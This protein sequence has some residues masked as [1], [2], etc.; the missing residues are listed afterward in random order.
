MPFAHWYYLPSSVNIMA[1]KLDLVNNCG[2]LT[3][4]VRKIKEKAKD[5]ATTPLTQLDVDLHLKNL[6]KL[7][8]QFNDLH[9]KILPLCTDDA[10]RETQDDAA[11]QFSEDI[12]E[13]M[14]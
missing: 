7:E 8:A 13:A 12:H 4:K 10:A 9:L 3:K 5:H 14:V 1:T 2:T 11:V 6:D